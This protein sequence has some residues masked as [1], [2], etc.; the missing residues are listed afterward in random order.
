MTYTR[1]QMEYLREFDRMAALRDMRHMP[2]WDI[3][4]QLAEQ[5]IQRKMAN[6]IQQDATSE[7]IVTRHAETK[8]V[9]KFFAMMR[10]LV[11][12]AVN[13]CDP[14]E[15]ELALYSLSQDPDL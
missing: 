9:M 2:G 11:D 10:D 12:N 3:F 1:E 7:Q 13:F 8:A 4:C 6:Y 15:V 14:R 5:H